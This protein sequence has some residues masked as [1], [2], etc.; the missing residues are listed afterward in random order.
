MKKSVIVVIAIIIIAL[1]ILFFLKGCEP[2]IKTDGDE[3][4]QTTQDTRT[5]EDFRDAF[6]QANTE[7]TCAIV[8]NPELTKD[9]E[10]LKEILDEAYER[11]TFPIE[12]NERMLEILGTYENDEAVISAIKANVA[13]CQG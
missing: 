2:R 10:Q 7:F 8:K 9:G 12:D 13:E 4:N 6:I 3:A 1:I 11:N 5:A